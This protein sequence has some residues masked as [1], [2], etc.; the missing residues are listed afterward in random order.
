MSKKLLL[1]NPVWEN[2]EVPFI[3]HALLSII[4]YLKLK[5]IPFIYC[6]LNISF[7]N[8]NKVEE[9]LGKVYDENE[10]SFTGISSFITNYRYTRSII[11][12][13]RKVTNKQIVIVGGSLGATLPK[14][15]Y[16]DL[17]A[18]LLVDKDGEYVLESI[19]KHKTHQ[20]SGLQ[21]IILNAPQYF[22]VSSMDIIPAYE[23]LDM[24]N[25]INKINESG[26]MFDII[27]GRGC[28]INCSYCFKMTGSKIRKKNLST[29][30]AELHYLKET[31]GISS[32][33]FDDDNFAISVSWINDFLNEL[34]EN[35]LN[36]K[37]RFQASLD[38]LGR[39]KLIERMQ[40]AGL[41][42]I[43]TG[44][45]SGSPTILK[46]MNKK[47]PIEKAQVY[48]TELRT[49]GLKMN[50]SFII[51]YPGE[52]ERSLEET[53]EF[54]N[55]NCE[56]GSVRVFFFTPYPKTLA[57]EVLIDKGI[58]NNEKEFVV[59]TLKTQDKLA[60]NC[61][62]MGDEVLLKYEGAMLS[63]GKE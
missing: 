6:D 7:E 28:P 13:I 24:E 30:I 44:I 48:L 51:G 22:D 62:G 57:Y 18:D 55:Q 40:K 37:W 19:Y 34:D 5:N 56:Y 33:G 14:S 61:T 39:F 25:Y 29:F 54:I 9:I 58:I 36:I 11:Q 42:G 21:N 12:I 53:L 17:G 3:P 26:Y 35:N 4:S 52:T 46:K 50:Y 45:E 16:S 43:S 27:S 2:S 1:I 32:F 63:A 49:M 41:I 38:T 31:Y 60:I 8:F 23:M 59:N 20:L 15:L 10:I 47:I